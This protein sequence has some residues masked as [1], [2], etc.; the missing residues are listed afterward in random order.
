MVPRD[1]YLSSLLAIRNEVTEVLVILIAAIVRRGALI[2][3]NVMSSQTLIS[4]ETAKMKR[5]EFTPTP[6]FPLASRHR[7]SSR[8]PGK[9]QDGDERDEQILP[10]IWC[11]VFTGMERNRSWAVNPRNSRFSFQI[12]KASRRIQNRFRRIASRRCSDCICRQ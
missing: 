11:A 4:N 7:R 9:S 5:F 2:L 12:S 1:Y 10:S 3:R 6:G 8:W